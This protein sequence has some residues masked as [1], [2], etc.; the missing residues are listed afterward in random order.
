MAATVTINVRNNSSALQSFFFFQRPAT[1]SYAPQVYTNS[2]FCQPLLP[3]A[4]S[5]AV[6]TF[7]LPLQ[8][9]AGV[10]Q[11]LNA[12]AVGAYAGELTASQP[13]GL[14]PPA[15]GPQTNNTTTMIVSPSLGLSV[16]VSSSGPSPGAFRIVTPVFNPQLAKY[17]GGLA[18]QAR[19]D[20]VVL[21]NFVTVQPNSN[22][23]C[24][25]QIVFYVQIGDCPAGTVIDFAASS[26]TAAVCDAT[27]GYSTFNVSYN[28]DGT[29]SVT[30]YA[31]RRKRDSAKP[32]VDRERET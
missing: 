5:G 19:T 25:P 8:N 1:Y 20:G 26:R 12:L 16:P 10:Q 11:Q 29:W 9:Y 23:D 31:L 15:G 28:A 4:T 24:Q 3:Y 18:M 21:S 32:S 13:I 7:S 30:A 6:L 17:S 22:L 14:T 27:P 2:L